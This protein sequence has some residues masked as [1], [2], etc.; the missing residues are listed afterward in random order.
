MVTHILSVMVLIHTIRQSSY[1]DFFFFFFYYKIK[2][3]IWII[4]LALVKGL[5]WEMASLLFRGGHR[6]L[7]DRRQK[8]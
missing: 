8:V 5:H 1:L 7:H 3:F 6:V 2:R 4:V